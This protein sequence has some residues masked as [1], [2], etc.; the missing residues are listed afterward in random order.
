MIPAS[1]RGLH[2]SSGRARMPF[3]AARC[4][5][6]PLILLILLTTEGIA[7]AQPLAHL[8][9]DLN[10]SDAHAI[11][12]NYQPT[13]ATIGTTVFFTDDDGGSGNE[14][15]KLDTTTGATA[16]VRDICPGPCSSS[17]LWLTVLGNLVIFRATDGPH[18][19]ELWRSDGTAEGTFLLHDVNPG[20]DGGS[21]GPWI[22]A[23]GG[24]V[25]FSGRDPILGVGLWSTDGTRAG[26]QLIA[27]VG[28]ASG[29]I[30]PLA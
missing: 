6:F 22:D 3:R 4:P 29:E 16:L 8:V 10:T 2:I 26:T 27:L 24:K 1:S 28:P 30:D 13:P 25:L 7:Q 15:W 18:G 5:R 9:R 17:P 21:A 23:V 14:L 20:G 11:G 12:D 19:N